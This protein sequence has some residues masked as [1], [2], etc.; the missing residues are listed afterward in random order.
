MPDDNTTRFTLSNP[1]RAGFYITDPFNSPRSYAN[2]RHEGVDLR[3]LTGGRP[4]EIVAAQRGVVDRIKSGNTGYGNYVRIRH[5]WADGTTW[6]TW[7]AHLSSINPTLQ[8]GEVVEAGQRLG[9][10]GTTGNSTGV[11]LHLTLQH[12]DLGLKGYVIPDVVD[13]TRFFSD[14]TIPV[15]DEMTYLADVTVPDGSPIEAGK[16][17]VKTWRV[18]NSGT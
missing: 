16:S 4:A 14:V 15:I 11:H 13:P 18:R 10:A 12:L 5:D 8:V 1:V 2:G 9:I 6:V 7:Y 17:F 3:A